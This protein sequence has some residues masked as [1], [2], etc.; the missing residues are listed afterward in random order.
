MIINFR[1]FLLAACT[2]TFLSI[3]LPDANAELSLYQLKYRKDLWPKTTTITRDVTVEL[4]TD[5]GKRFSS[6]HLRK[7]KEYPVEAIEAT[8]VVIEV[9]GVYGKLSAD[10][11]DALSKVNA[12][13]ARQRQKEEAAKRIEDNNRRLAELEQQRKQDQEAFLAANPPTAM[14]R[15]LGKTLLHLQGGKLTGYP[16]ESLAGVKY[17]AIYFSAHWC[18]PCR[19]FT[20]KLVNW[21]NSFKP[22]HPNFE[23]IFVSSDRS[24]GAM[25]G[26]MRG[27]RMPW[28]AVSFSEVS[29]SPLRRFAG[30]G[31]PCLVLVD[32]TGKVLAHSYVNGSYVGPT[33]VMQKIPQIVR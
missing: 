29:T 13:I 1:N 33:S 16:N 19:K 28:P 18:P 24:S 23:L 5:K 30:R 26:Y 3:G 6:M 8:G 4:K 27:S 2:F 15:R 11:C 32:S 21:Y 12:R 14:Q 17:Y 10:E 20:P 7:G 22:K 31:I 9:L 25:A